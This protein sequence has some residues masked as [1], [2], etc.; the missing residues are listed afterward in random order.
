MNVSPKRVANPDGT[1]KTAHKT[2]IF[3]I[4]LPRIPDSAFPI[5]S[6][7]ELVAKLSRLFLRREPGESGK[8]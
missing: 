2:A 3:P 6:H 4:N 1:A 8:G 7:E 5:N